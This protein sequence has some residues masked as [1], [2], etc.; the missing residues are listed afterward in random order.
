MTL[1]GLRRV[2]PAISRRRRITGTEWTP[3]VLVAPGIEYVQS[4]VFTGWVNEFDLDDIAYSPSSDNPET[5]IGSP[6]ARRS[7]A[8]IHLAAGFWCG[9][10]GAPLAGR[11]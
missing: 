7:P 9:I 5:A 10:D 11:A 2:Q 8:H 6:V 1:H 4:G 3:V